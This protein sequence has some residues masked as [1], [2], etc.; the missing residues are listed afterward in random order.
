MEK[1]VCSMILMEMGRKPDGGPNQIIQAENALRHL[2]KV[3][4]S[5][6]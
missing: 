2:S 1:V 4:N 3:K 6:N 5:P